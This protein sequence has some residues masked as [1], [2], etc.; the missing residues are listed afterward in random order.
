MKKFLTALIAFVMC[1]SVVTTA[2]AATPDETSD[3]DLISDIKQAM[4]DTYYGD[5]KPEYLNVEILLDDE[6][7][8]YFSFSDSFA[9]SANRVY[10]EAGNYIVSY[11]ENCPV[12][13]YKNNRVYMIPDAYNSGVIDD[14]TLEGLTYCGHMDIVPKS[15]DSALVIEIKNKVI[16]ECFDGKSPETLR[17]DIVGRTSDGG[18]YF[19]HS[20]GGGIDVMVEETIGDY[21]YYYNH[22]DDVMLYKNG[23]VYLIKEAY[24][25]GVIDDSILEE[26]SK[27]NFGLESNK[28][29]TT[30]PTEP[31]TTVAT[32][33]EP[34]TVPDTTSATKP[35]ST[36]DTATND[37]PNNLQNNSGAVQTGQN[38]V[39]VILLVAM[40]AGCAVIFAK[41]RNHFE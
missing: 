23:N 13:L 22:N 40:L 16:E 31:T 8:V 27:M 33:D 18:V 37:T 39:A 9:T 32:V 29:N 30:V 24:E 7:G 19:K 28:P 1:F 20:V 36:S 15:D 2:F 5:E 4:L 10:T 3:S 17:I 25:S 38:S 6:D 11:P 26:L 12:A 21:T 35:V 41:R 34:V 14:D